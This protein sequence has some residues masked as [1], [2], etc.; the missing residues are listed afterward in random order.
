MRVSVTFAVALGSLAIVALAAVVFDLSFE[1][2][3]LLAPAIVICVGMAFG[4]V[5]L[6][7][8]A[9]AEPWRRRRARL[10]PSDGARSVAG[11]DELDTRPMRS[12]PD[13]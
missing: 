10:N 3:A 4:L 2:A 8:K 1:R 12:R 7:G 6:W 13:G 9:A 11:P 5:V